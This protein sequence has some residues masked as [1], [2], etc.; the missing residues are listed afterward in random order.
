MNTESPQI[1]DSFTNFEH[2]IDIKG[3]VDHDE[4]FKQELRRTF[5]LPLQNVSC[6]HLKASFKSV[7][8]KIQPAQIA[9]MRKILQHDF[10]EIDLKLLEEQGNFTK[11]M[12][13][14]N[15]INW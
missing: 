5:G 4:V 8:E 3:P 12:A 14:I 6:D 7:L 1:I 2:E 13:E 10:Y 9:A 15:E 11:E